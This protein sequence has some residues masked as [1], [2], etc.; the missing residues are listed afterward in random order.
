MNLTKIFSH[1]IL[2]I[3]RSGCTAGAS[4]SYTSDIAVFDMLEP[5]RLPLM[6]E[7]TAH[8]SE[9]CWRR[10]GRTTVGWRDSFGSPAISLGL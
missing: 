9:E 5:L 10:T 2:E 3:R 6:N 8:S 4:P 7:Q 1:Y